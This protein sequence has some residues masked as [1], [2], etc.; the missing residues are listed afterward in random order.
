AKLD[1]PTD[2]ILY[3]NSTDVLDTVNFYLKNKGVSNL[4]VSGVVF[5][6][7]YASKY[8]LV[9]SLPG[10]IAPNDSG[11]FR[12]TSNPLGRPT[13]N[14]EIQLDNVQ[15]ATMDISTNDPT[16]PTFKVSLQSDSPLPVE[17]IGF[18]SNVNKNNVLLN[19]STASELNNK[20][21]EV[22]RKE[23]NSSWNTV[24]FVTGKG[25]SNQTNNYTFED[26]NVN[27]GNLANEVSVGIP[28]EFALQQ[29]Y[30]NP[31]NPTTTINF[32][33]PVDAKVNLLIYDVTGRL[34]SEVVNSEFKAGINSVK[35]N[36]ANFASGIYFYSINISSVT[37]NFIETKRMVLVK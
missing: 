24:S 6:G 7:T 14:S 23:V 8:T 4:T 2:S 13:K 27:T 25:T 1:S 29:N 5:N 11:L 36:A 9:S 21:F 12:V 28:K 18:S 26:K 33:L 16:K 35:F 32:D 22:E 30:P 10:A 37:G 15:N 19:W 34:I 3:F 17:L 20:G 31:F